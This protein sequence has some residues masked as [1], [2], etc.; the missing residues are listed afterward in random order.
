MRDDE[1]ENKQQLQKEREEKH[2]Q[3]RQQFH[4][5]NETRFVD[6][7]H[8]LQRLSETTGNNLKYWIQN[9]SWTFCPTCFSLKPE[10]L[11]QRYKGQPANKPLKKCLCADKKYI[12]PTL[13]L[14]PDCLRNLSFNEI[15][16]LRP[17]NFHFGDYRRLQNGYQQKNLWRVDWSPLSVEQKI[18]GMEEDVAKEGVQRAYNFLMASEESCYSQFINMRELQVSNE[19]RPNLYNLSEMKGIECALWPNLYPFTSWCESIL[20]GNE[21]R[22]STKISFYTK[23]LSSI[24]DYSTVYE[25]LQFHYNFSLWPIFTMLQFVTFL[26]HRFWSGTSF[27]T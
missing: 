19:K 17:F 9:S 6:N 3:Q 2:E 10:K 14:I 1:L 13:C 12:V 23:V 21:Q 8:H 11:L 22:L 26:F 16:I 25:L 27:Y 4:V 24:L 20:D 5:S 7:L 15:C 18:D